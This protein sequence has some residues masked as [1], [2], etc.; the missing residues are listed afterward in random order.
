MKHVYRLILNSSTYQLSSI[1]SSTPPERESSFAH[2][3]MRPLD[4][5][6][7]I[8]ALNQ[9]TGA[10]EEYSSAIPEPFTFIPPDKRS[11]AL[12]DG[13][14]RSAFLETFGRPPRDTG[15][16]SERTT[17]PDGGAAAATCSIRATCSASSQQGPKLQALLLRQGGPRDVIN[18]LYLTILSRYPTEA[19][20]RAI[21]GYSQAA[22]TQPARSGTGP[23]VGAHQHCG[24]RVQ[25]LARDSGPGLKPR[26]ATDCQTAAQESSMSITRR[27]ALRAGLVGAAGLW[28]ADRNGAPLRAAAPTGRA[29]AVI[30][31]WMWGG[32][33]HI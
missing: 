31:I 3:L 27:E 17:Q 1:S 32:P 28:F 22:G 13:S 9:I 12:A 10:G 33:C 8:D 26:A 7:L 5:E 23:G 6:V 20:L 14:I 16:A 19:E 21:T 25:A 24:V 4:A 29:K 30:Q 15:L 2:A 11:I 18:A